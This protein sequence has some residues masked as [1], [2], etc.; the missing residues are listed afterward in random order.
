MIPHDGGDGSTFRVPLRHLEQL[1]LDGDFHPV[2]RLLHRLDYPESMDMKLYLSDCTVGDISGTLGPYLGGYIRHGGRFQKGLDIFIDSS[3]NTIQAY[4]SIVTDANGPGLS[5]AGRASFAMV[6]AA[7]M[8]LLP[9]E[10]LDR[11]YIDLVACIP[12]ERVVCFGADLRLDVVKEIVTLMPNIQELE[13]VHATLSERFLQPNPD[14]PLANTKLLPSLRYLHLENTD[15]GDWYPLVPYLVHQTSGGQIVSLRIK[16]GR[17]H[18]CPSVVES[19]EGLVE[20]VILDM[21]LEQ[22]CPL[23]ICQEGQ[24]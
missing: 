16:G 11:L 9:P 21:T 4:F 19:I 14:G 5:L 18:I 7:P 23:G 24:K 20:E 15:A 10:T 22:E 6:E 12:R 3:S 8:E 1:D 17:G 2:F 13:L